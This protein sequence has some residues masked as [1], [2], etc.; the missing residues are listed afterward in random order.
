M[1]QCYELE[2]FSCVHKQ[3]GSVLFFPCNFRNHWT[4]SITLISILIL[5]NV[6]QFSLALAYWAPVHND[7]QWERLDS[8]CWVF[9]AIICRKVSIHLPW[10]HNSHLWKELNMKRQHHYLYSIVCQ[11]FLYEQASKCLHKKVI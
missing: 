10:I 5:S 1:L 9:V 7:G 6:S 3:W 8:I 4:L 2:I 11:W